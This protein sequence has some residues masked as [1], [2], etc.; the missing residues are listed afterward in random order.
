MARPIFGE[1]VSPTRTPGETQWAIGASDFRRTSKPHCISLHPILGPTS[2]NLF[3]FLVLPLPPFLLILKH[4][5]LAFLFE[6][7][8]P[9]V[10]LVKKQNSRFFF[11]GG[12]EARGVSWQ[13]ARPIFGEPVSPTYTPG[14]MQWAIGAS[15]FRRTCKPHCISL[16]P[17]WG[18]PQT[19]FRFW[20]AGAL[21]LPPFLPF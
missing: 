20:F 5:T 19:C 8:S 18:Q 11:G 9:R 21:P 6:S 14:E 3:S 7:S 4:K 16:H 13:L 1:P 10:C 12:S 17:I 2:E 15:D